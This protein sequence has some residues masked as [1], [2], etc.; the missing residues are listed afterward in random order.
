MY[1]CKC[2]L[3]ILSWEQEEGD[4][5]CLQCNHICNI[6]VIDELKGEELK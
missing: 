4:T 3:V 6:E 5:P 2:G 1:T